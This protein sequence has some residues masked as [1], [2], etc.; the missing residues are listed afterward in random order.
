MVL[1]TPDGT[2]RRQL[3]T[4]ASP[5]LGGFPGGAQRFLTLFRRSR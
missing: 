1:I 2:A 3:I 5:A 4:P